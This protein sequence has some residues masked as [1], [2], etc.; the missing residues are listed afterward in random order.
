VAQTVVYTLGYQG[1]SAE[2][3]VALLRERGVERLVDVRQVA[4]SRKRG[5]SK[6]SLRE[7]LEDA[8][9]EYLHLPELGN[10]RELREADPPPEEL[11]RRYREHLRG[12]EAMVEALYLLVQQKSTAL[13]CYERD[14]AACH[15]IVL[16]EELERRGARVEHL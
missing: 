9:L 8:G 11:R 3:L 2:E 13:M 12:E 16:A 15:R 1:R 5:F 6:T 4:L 10:P 7:R 14:P